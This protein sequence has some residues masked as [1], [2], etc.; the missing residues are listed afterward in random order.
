[1]RKSF[2]IS[3]VRTIFSI[4]KPIVVFEVQ[5]GDAIVRN[6]K[7]ALIDLQNSGRALSINPV[8]FAHGIEAVSQDTKAKFIT[9]LLDTVGAVVSG[10]ITPVKK[11]DTYVANEYSS[12]ITDSSHPLFNKVKVGDV[13]TVEADSS[14]RV[15]GFLSIPLLEQ[16]KMRRDLTAAM[17]DKMLVMFGF[18][19]QVPQASAP[20]AYANPLE[21]QAP[22]MPTATEAE[23]FGQAKATTT[24]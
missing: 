1:M 17:A 16:D 10:D 24:K 4:A 22:A 7:Q 23:A 18:G 5:G 19:Q 3:N 20:V 2:V 6:P 11:G 14:P 15:E 8:E 13:V 21:E 9:A 12:V